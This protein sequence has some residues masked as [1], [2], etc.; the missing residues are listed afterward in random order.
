MT[1]K[2]IAPR[3]VRYGGAMMGEEE[4]RAVTQVMKLEHGMQVGAN[5][6]EFENKVSKLLGK[7]YGAM[8]NSGSSALML[9]VRLLDLP[10]GS[11]IITPVLTFSTDVASIVHAGHVPVFVDVEVDTYQIDAE[12][13]ERMIGPK[14]KAMLVPNLVGGMP[15]WDRLR[16][17][18]DKHELLLIEDSADTLGGT[19]RGRPAGERADISITS[20]SLFHIMTCLGNGGMVCVD[21][22][23][24]WDRALTLRCWG[25]SSE[26]FLYGRVRRTATAV[27]WKTL[28]ICP[29]TAC[30]CSRHRLRIH[31]QRGRRRFRA[32]AVEE[33]GSFRRTAQRQIRAPHGVAQKPRG[34]F[35][36]ATRAGACRHHLDLLSLAA[37]P[38]AGLDRR[39]LQIHLED[40]A[41]HARDLLPATSLASR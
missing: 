24:L 40:S 29:M 8:V 9:A 20:F 7:K 21:D 18:A 31:P 17:I 33:A 34:Y 39:A 6:M 5:V 28:A 30:F 4:I 16:E 35:S 36:A 22:E 41:F 19:F 10:K 38:D 37:A 12:A 1:T 25:R 27:F 14:T 26:K 32:G 2:K 3:E 11:E 23:K 13:V 15:D